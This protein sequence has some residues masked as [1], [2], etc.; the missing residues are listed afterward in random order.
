MKKYTLYIGLNDKDS[1]QQEI[2]LLDAYKVATN[3]F[4]ETTGGATI[5]EAKGIYTHDDG[6]IVVE[7]S[8]RCEIFGAEDDQIMKAVDILKVAF[9]QESIAVESAEVNSCFM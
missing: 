3:V 1:K 8:L 7:T 6:T 9:N 4:V 5:S 2:S